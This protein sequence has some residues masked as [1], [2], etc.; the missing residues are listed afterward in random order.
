MFAKDIS[1]EELARIGPIVERLLE[2]GKLTEDEKWAVD[3]SCRA[4]TDFAQIRHSEIAKAFYARPD[5][6]ERCAN[7]INEWLAD[8][9]DAKPGTVTAICGRMYV[10]SYDRDGNLGLFPLLDL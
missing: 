6:E 2:S 3:Q 10:A 1:I 4:A 8:N 5:I 9:I 7:S